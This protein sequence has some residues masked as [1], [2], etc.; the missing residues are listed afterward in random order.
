MELENYFDKSYIDYICE[1]DKLLYK[2][3]CGVDKISSKMVLLNKEK[4]FEEI[5]TKI[6][7]NK[8]KFSKY[9]VTL[10]SKG[11]NKIPRK[12]CTPTVKDKIVINMIKHILYDKYN[13]VNFN[14]TASSIIK[15]I[16]NIKAQGIYDSFIKLDLKEFF[17]NID[18]N[19]LLNKISER[20]EDNRILNLISDMLKTNQLYDD[21]SSSNNKNLLGV[22]QGLSISMLFSNIY[23]HEFD[24]DYENR[25]DIK[26][27]RYVDDIFIMHKKDEKDKI[28][29]EIE[30]ILQRRYLLLLNNVKTDCGSLSNTFDYLGY[31]FSNNKIQVRDSSIRKFEKSI[32]DMFIKL[33]Y[34]KDI[35]DNEINRFVWLLNVKITGLLKDNKRYGWL[36]YFSMIDDLSI[37]KK[38]D[39]LIS[40]FI[41]RFK[42]NEKLGNRK[43]KKFIRA[44]NEI[45]NNLKDSKYILNL[46]RVTKEEKLEFLENICGKNR[47]TLEEMEEY[48]FKMLY[49]NSIYRIMKNLE[50]DVDKMSG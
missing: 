48:E 36:F 40:K 8:Y 46:N 44:F 27:F 50:K 43:I 49:E 35:S 11:V 17:D 23:L 38:L 5:S 32:E 22:P 25:D 6:L 26:Y 18:H 21:V 12:T 13:D 30:R 14:K 19:I 16:K 10:I 24:L 15:E 2:N 33:S 4:Y 39:W 37:L 42:L 29:E 28:C 7:N 34:K 45:N 3:S 9:K 20:V 47:I 41:S 1:E 31:K